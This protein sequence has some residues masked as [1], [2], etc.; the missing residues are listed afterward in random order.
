VQAGATGKNDRRERRKLVD[1]EELYARDISGAQWRKSSKSLIICVEVAEIGGG[2]VAL[3]DSKNPDRADI[4]FT[5]DEWAAF[6]EGV[7][8]GEF[9]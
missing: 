4:R 8:D 1:K 6:R 5:P 9:G 2:A 7:R 3:R